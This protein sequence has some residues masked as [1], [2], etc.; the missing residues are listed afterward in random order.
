M[1]FVARVRKKRSRRVAR[2]RKRRLLLGDNNGVRVI[3]SVTA[4]GYTSKPIITANDINRVPR[5][6]RGTRARAELQSKSSLLTIGRRA[7]GAEFGAQ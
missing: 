2:G 6:Q 7:V 4:N 1:P 3:R 5:E